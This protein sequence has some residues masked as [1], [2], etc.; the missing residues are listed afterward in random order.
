MI[1]NRSRHWLSLVMAGAIVCGALVGMVSARACGHVK[2]SR[3]LSAI[4]CKVIFEGCATRR[5]KGIPIADSPSPDYCDSPK[6]HSCIGAFGEWSGRKVVV[7]DA[8]P[9]TEN[10]SGLRVYFRGWNFCQTYIAISRDNSKWSRPNSEVV[11]GRLAP[12][13][14]LTAMTVQQAG[15]KSNGDDI[16]NRNVCAKLTLRCVFGDFVLP[17]H[18]NSSLA[19][20]LHSFASQ[21]NLLVEENGPNRR[22]QDRSH[23]RS[24]HPKR[25]KRTGLLGGEI[26]LVVILGVGGAGVCYQ[27]FERAGKARNIWQT[28]GWAVVV[29]LSGLAAS[30]GLILLMVGTV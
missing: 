1:E 23:G 17:L 4:S 16:F 25:P 11:S 13:Y 15:L 29:A 9:R 30:Y 7:N 21:D 24:N 10:C 18:R 12:I 19:S 2:F 27:A 6:A 20:V 22:N 14:H 3:K 8:L 5:P 28:L 26:A